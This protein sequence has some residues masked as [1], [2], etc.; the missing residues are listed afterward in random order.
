[1]KV[2]LG[3]TIQ[4]GPWGGGN[5]FAMAL[6]DAL[7]DSG[8]SVVFSLDDSDIDIILLT[9][10]RARSKNVAFGAG[11]IFRYLL[12]KNRDVIVLHR[13]NECDERKNT[14]FMNAALARANY[15]AD[16]TVFVGSWLVDLPV[17]KKSLRTPYSVILNGADVATFNSS[18]FVPWTRSGPLRLV[19]HHWGGN[20]MKGF[21]VYNNIDRMLSQ[22]K[23]KNRIEFTYVGNLPLGIEFENVRVLEP[24]NGQE[25]CDEL[26]SHHAYVTASICEP[27]GN[28]QNEAGACGLPILYRNSGCLPEYCEGYGIQ[29]EPDTF[30]QALEAMIAEYDR[31]CEQMK[32][33]PHWASK[34]C[35]EY[36]SLFEDLLSRRAQIVADRN[37]FRRPW[38]IFRNQFPF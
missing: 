2:A 15:C 35:S 19:T 34:T 8:H 32:D 33:W 28:H 38:Q 25:L 31:Y 11:E 5:R 9:D 18:K 7:R 37:I 22:P 1:M 17:W 16:F 3:Y 23:W 4:R 12:F 6:A 30:E 36:I 20:W 14:D 24:L 21:D 10:P 13:I 29:F 26:C 27:G